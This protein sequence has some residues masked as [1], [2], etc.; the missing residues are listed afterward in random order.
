MILS[1]TGCNLRSSSLK[2]LCLSREQ[3]Y[4]MKW[5]LK[6]QCVHN[7]RASTNYAKFLKFVRQSWKKLSCSRKTRWYIYIERPGSV[8]TLLSLNDFMKKQLKQRGFYMISRAVCTGAYL[9][10]K[11]GKSRIS[12]CLPLFFSLSPSLSFSLSLLHNCSFLIRIF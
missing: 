5:K 11:G 2:H 6:T 12:V 7:C 9:D 3:S 8:S 10:S 4:L 1:Q